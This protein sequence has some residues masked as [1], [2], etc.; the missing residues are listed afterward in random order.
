MKSIY[1]YTFF[2]KFAISPNSLVQN[3]FLFSCRVYVV[4][5]NTP[6]SQK[7]SN[8]FLY[9]MCNFDNCEKII[10]KSTFSLKDTIP[11]WS[12]TK[13]QLKNENIYCYES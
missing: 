6:H 13:C 11:I 7:W 12:A 10:L 8:I 1:F 4:C 3:V 2:S 5:R 9:S